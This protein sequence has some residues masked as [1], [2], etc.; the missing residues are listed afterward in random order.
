MKTN[1]RLFALEQS[2]LVLQS[3]YNDMVRA[4]DEWRRIANERLE[5]IQRQEK[6]LERAVRKKP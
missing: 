4:K 3:Q 6:L 1:D 2:L 5:I